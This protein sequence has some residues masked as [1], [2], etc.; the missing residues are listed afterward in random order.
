MEGADKLYS[1]IPKT[2]NLK[3]INST[4]Y[5]HF[6]ETFI[7]NKPEKAIWIVKPG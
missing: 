4:V 1:F 2:Y 7:Q 3:D 6:L 5:S